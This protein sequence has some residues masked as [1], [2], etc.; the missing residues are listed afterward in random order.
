METYDLKQKVINTNAINVSLRS[1]T[2]RCFLDI[3]ATYVPSM[4]LDSNAI[5]GMREKLQNIALEE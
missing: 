1:F 2:P 3:L 5:V 4:T